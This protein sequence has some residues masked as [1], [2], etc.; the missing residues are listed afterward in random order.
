[1]APARADCGFR[2]EEPDLREIVEADAATIGDGEEAARPVAELD[3]LAGI[4]Q[5]FGVVT[6]ASSSRIRLVTSSAVIGWFPR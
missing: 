2:S 5:E 3:R 4:A 6:E 1:M